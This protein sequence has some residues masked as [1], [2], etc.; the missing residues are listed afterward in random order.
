MPAE[1]LERLKAGNQRFVSNQRIFQNLMEQ[2]KQTAG[3]QSPFAAILGCIDSR[4]VP[5]L[6]FDQ[7]IG[8]LFSIR[9]AGNVI[10]EDVLA[11]LEFACAIAGTRLIVVKGHT[12]CGAIAAACESEG[13]GHLHQLI[14]KI[15]PSVEA[16]RKQLGEDITPQ[17]RDEV[18]HLNVLRSVELIQ[19]K[20]PTL[21]ELAA[22]GEIA[23]IGALYD[24]VSGEVTFYG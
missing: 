21:R 14:S 4:T 17:L 15:K 2:V 7:G 13:E 20:S 10:S 8:S 12:R 11:S 3:G 16:A 18:S 24:V 22:S 5:E 9:V 6:I 1:A 23:I 19:E